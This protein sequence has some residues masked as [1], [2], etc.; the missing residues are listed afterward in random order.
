MAEVDAR[1][2]ATRRASGRLSTK[3][4]AQPCPICGIVLAGDEL[5]RHAE[6]C[7]AYD[8]D[9]YSEAAYPSEAEDSSSDESFA[10]PITIWTERSPDPKTPLVMT[11]INK[12]RPKAVR[13]RPPPKKGTPWPSSR[14]LD[15]R[16]LYTY[17]TALH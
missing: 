10:E 12:P 17:I 3:A 1:G 16:I 4:R 2:Y 13:N 14:P 6:T 15:L 9:N 7:R 11:F 5:L 8:S